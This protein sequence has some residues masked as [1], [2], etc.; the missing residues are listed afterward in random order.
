M[1]PRILNN[2][3]SLLIIKHASISYNSEWLEALGTA[4]LIKLSSKYTMARMLE[5]DDFGKRFQNQVGI[6]IHEFLYPLLQGY[7][8]RLLDRILS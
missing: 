2:Y 5:R 6:G 8:S 1:Q 7:D 4:G 3:L